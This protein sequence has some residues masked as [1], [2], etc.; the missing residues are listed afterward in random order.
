[1][2]FQ[3]GRVGG[4]RPG[5]ATAVP[6]EVHIVDVPFDRAG[7]PV[8]ARAVADEPDDEA[9][10][11]HALVEAVRAA[12]ASLGVPAQP[13][14]WL[15][16]LPALL[17]LDEVSAA[18]PAAFGAGGHEASTALPAAPYGLVDLPDR[19][20]V[21]PA[22]LDVEH[23][24]HLA[25]A[26]APRSGR[27]TLL[28]TVAGSVAS[29]YDP[30]DVHVYGLDCGNGA[31]LPLAKL[32]H[33]G[34]VV[35]RTETER[36]GRLLD[37]LA[38]EISARQ[39][40]LAAAGF[41][42]VAEQRAGAPPDDRLPYL[43]L[44]VDRWEG[45]TTAYG[46]IDNGRHNDTM[47]RLLR[48]GPS[49]GLRV[50]VAGDRS[51]L[52]GKLAG[53]IEDRLCLRLADR[54]DYSLA[55]LSP[56]KLP[57]EL[58]AGQAFRTA[59][60]RECQVAVL[61]VPGAD[62]VDASGSGQAAALAAIAESW[63][64]EPAPAHR[65]FRVDVLPPRLSLDEARS[66]DGWGAGPLTPIVGVGGDELAPIAVDLEL[67]GPGFTVAGPRRSGRSTA[68]LG[69]ATSLL[70]AGGTV[71][72]LAPRP[73]PLRSLDGRPGVAAVVTESDPS[74][75]QVV[76][77]LNAVDGNM[78]IVVDDAELLH[79][80]DIQ[81][82]L[83]QVLRDGRDQGHAMVVG[84]TTEELLRAMRGFTFDARSSRAGLILTPESHLQG[85]LLGVRL[86]RS[87]VFTGPAGRGFLTLPGRST[88]VQVPLVVPEEIGQPA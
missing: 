23:G 73:S 64:S 11:L 56:R 68:L 10:D 59:D 88:L 81:E 76:E 37:R 36:G 60:E 21:A 6:A 22:A 35:S 12:D 63:A 20:Q 69:I 44:L 9:T 74:P 30:D 77:V 86:P 54:G 53:A 17:P 85:E 58:R 3:S 80:S 75:Q 2:A 1:L 47:L 72:V 61:G 48:E 31:L 57:D 25:V 5:A 66:L 45:F 24:G 38:A 7:Y 28:R 49:A 41:A 46:E 26:G 62:E 4:R 40:S 32:P 87:A 33:C 84:G 70:G 42:D 83:Q 79:P 71:V 78:V 34:T 8:P 18:E 55:G 16:P 67:Y 27:S 82:L 15:A 14:P 65:P 52:L 39:E 50:V 19:Q 51:V 13:S 29:S 43:L